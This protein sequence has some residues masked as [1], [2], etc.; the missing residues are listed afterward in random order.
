VVAVNA[1]AALEDQQLST[2]FPMVDI[3]MRCTR[4]MGHAIGQARA[5]ESANVVV[6]PTLG[7][8]TML[9][10][11]KSPKIIECG[12]RAAEANLPAIMAGYERIKT[13]QVARQAN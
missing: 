9:D 4:I 12:R 7:D 11:A 10:F 2:R 6:T 13:R 1:M 5:E 8:I 3:M